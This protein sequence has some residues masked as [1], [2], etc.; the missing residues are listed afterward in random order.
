MIDHANKM[1]KHEFI[2]LKAITDQIILEFFLGY[3]RVGCG[4]MEAYRLTGEKVGLSQDRVSKIV[5][6]YKK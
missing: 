2:N 4:Y 6:L 5:A 1:K 3:L